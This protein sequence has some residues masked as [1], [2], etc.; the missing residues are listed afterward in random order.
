MKVLMIAPTPFFSDR[1]CHVRI[2]EE[3]KV[4]QSLGHQVTI[5]TYHIG[6][7]VEGIEIRRM[8]PLFFWYKKTAAGPSWQKPLLLDPLLIL[9]TLW[10]SY[11][12]SYDIVHGHLHEGSIIGWFASRMRINKTPLLFDYQGSLTGELLSHHF[13]RGRQELLKAFRFGEHLADKAAD[14]IICSSSKGAEDLKEQF[15]IQEEKIRVLLDGADTEIFRPG[16]KDE[17]LRQKLSLPSDKKLVGYLGVLS[18][19]QGVDL[20]L[21]AIPWIL[22]NYPDVHFLIMGYPNVEGYQNKVLEMELDKVV[23][24]T[25]RIPY[26]QASNYLNLVDVAV[27]PKVSKTEANGKLYNYMALGLPTVVFDSDVNREILGNLGIYAS[28]ANYQ[29]LAEKMINLLKDENQQEELRGKL[30][31]RC[32]AQFSWKAQG[33]KLEKIYEEVLRKKQP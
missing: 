31:Q 7:D 12:E 9:S 24:F 32:Q 10:T 22:K 19:Y 6:K 25:G 16:P 20:L 15:N 21:E 13:I 5:S 3:A 30:R 28:Y 29:D 27:A 17:D 11:Q 18:A 2:L 8:P 33:K 14:L 1:G 26:D 23:T 4:L